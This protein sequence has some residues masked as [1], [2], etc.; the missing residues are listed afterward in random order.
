MAE[1]IEKP[2]KAWVLYLVYRNPRRRDMI[3]AVTYDVKIAEAWKK[4]T[5]TEESY[6]YA[7]EVPVAE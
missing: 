2:E 7:V 5:P 6:F 1:M 3:R 4:K